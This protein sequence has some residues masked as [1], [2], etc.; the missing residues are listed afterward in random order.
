MLS[1]KKDKAE[2]SIY[3][4]HKKIID[5]YFWSRELPSPNFYK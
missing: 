2:S 3:I 4:A 1:K 5:D